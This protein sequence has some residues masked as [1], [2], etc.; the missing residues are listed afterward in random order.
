LKKFSSKESEILNRIKNPLVFVT[1]MLSFVVLSVAFNRTSAAR[2]ARAGELSKLGG[3]EAVRFLKDNGMY[4]PLAAATGAFVEQARLLASDGASQDN[5]GF[6]VAI[7]GDTAVVGAPADAVNSK[8]RQGSVYVYVRTGTTWTQQQKL[9]SSDGAAN[10]EFGYSVAIVGDTI[11]A[12]R[13]NTQTGVNRTR[14]SVYIF[15]RTGA[16]WA[17][18]QILTADDGVEG[19]I[20]GTSL[21]L[22]N[23]TLVVG[24]QQKMIG[25]NFFQGAVYVFTRGSASNSFAQ[26]ARLTANDGGFADFFGYSVAVGGDT[27]IVGTPGLAGSGAASG[28]GWAYVYVRSG[29]TWTQQQKLL[30]SDGA[31]GDAFGYSVG[32][33]GDTAIIGARA[34]VVGTAGEVGSAYI[35][36]RA[37]VVWAEQQ[38]LTAAETTPRNDFFGNSVAIVG[39]TVVVGS[40]A[41]EFKPGVANHGAIYVFGR[42]GAL[43]TRQQKLL[44]ADFAPDNLGQSVAFDGASILGGAPAK[45]SARGAAYVFAREAVDPNRINGAESGQASFSGRSVDIDGDTA[46]ISADNDSIDGTENGARTGAAYIFVRTGAT[47]TQQARLTPPDGAN[48]DDFSSGVAI[49]G[50][51]AIVGA[52]DHKVGA[53]TGQGAAYVYTRSGTT[54]TLQQKLTAND[55]SVFDYFGISVDISG[56]TAVVSA[57]G[58]DVFATNDNRGSVYVFAR[59]GA[60]WA[61]QAKFTA[62][63]DRVGNAFGVDVAVDG[64]TVVVGNSLE[65]IGATQNQGAAYIFTRTGATW[66]EQQRLFKATGGEN[67]DGFGVSVAIHGETLVVGAAGFSAVGSKGTAYVYVRA[68]S[69]WT[70]QQQLLSNDLEFSDQLGKAVG[71]SGDTVILGA[72]SDAFGS[73]SNQGSAYIFK[74]AGSTWTQTQKLFATDGSQADFFGVSVAVS[75]DY[76]IAGAHGDDVGDK[77]EQGSAYIFALGGANPP[78]TP[79]PA[80]VQFSAASYQF[81]ES[82]E[83]ATITITRGGDT[84]AAASVELRTTDDPAAV[85]CD[86]IVNNAGAAYARCDYATT[87]ETVSWP[88][89]DAQPRQVTIPLI[90][91]GHVESA[92]NVQLRLVGTQGASAGVPATAMLVILDNDT[93]QT[94][95]P[96]YT[97]SFFVRT[98]YL[99]FLSREPEAGEPWT[100]VL[101]NCSDVNNNPACDRITVSSAFFRS[102]EFQIKGLY[103]YLLYKS[104]FNRRPT[105]DE[106]IPD[107]RSVTGQTPEEVY[108]K[109]AAFAAS[110]AAR[111]EFTNLYGAASNQAFVDALLGRYSLQQI[112]T[113]DPAMPDAAGQ[114]TLTR[115]QLVDGLVSGSLTRAKALRALVQSNEVEAA[116]F[117]GAFVA[118]QYYGYLRRSPEEGGYNNWLN[119]LNTNPGDFR[120][121]VNGF[122]NSVEYRLRFGRP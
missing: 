80:T 5:M 96:I 90:N 69:A 68:N 86:D 97:N 113:E 61:Q 39:D 109:K 3:Q 47:W 22:E 101:N 93:A 102:A 54:W 89:G 23:D 45:N 57:S 20:F 79:M 110:F 67:G 70:L 116:E 7:S 103:I 84:T 1:I 13:H 95:N 12:G 82:A 28:R 18:Q 108:Q 30:A 100:A 58:D 81:N 121:M 118:M 24:A 85:R 62:Q 66:T 27:V 34:D 26:Q 56:D 59:T 64:D 52:Y 71:I 48:G 42:T 29:A 8:N 41:H 119:Y 25:S 17:E 49:S 120:T 78:P 72:F 60:T 94:T 76:A 15:K 50:N 32:I 19:D 6:S 40:P 31:S 107:M 10:D 88:A 99:D 75:G 77:Q 16:T 11:A 74:R 51:T 53:N 37:G 55:G 117:N 4:E 14:G 92:E 38:K 91:D 122:M 104:A 21:A 35:F 46:I 44:H 36:T 106:I 83:S 98:N 65:T 73:N 43:W 33:S 114:V 63:A 87:V 115:Q 105:Y 9:N 2:S 112:T 111:Q